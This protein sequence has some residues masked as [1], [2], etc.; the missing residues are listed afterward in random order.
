SLTNLGSFAGAGND[1]VHVEVTGGAA[2]DFFL[3]LA[4][5]SNANRADFSGAGNNG[6]SI[7]FDGHAGDNGFGDT[8]RITNMNF[9]DAGSAIAGP[10]ENNG[11][12]LVSLNST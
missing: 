11:F 8:F 3:N 12:S 1:G 2:G 9:N 6:L 10:D 7:E 5:T 4:G